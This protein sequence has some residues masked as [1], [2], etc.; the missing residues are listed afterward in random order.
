MV[1]MTDSKPR[2]VIRSIVSS[3]LAS[4]KITRKEHLQLSSAILADQSITDEERRQIN[5]VFDYVQTGRLRVV[6]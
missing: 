2:L 1:W 5:R 6:D 4:G 3:I